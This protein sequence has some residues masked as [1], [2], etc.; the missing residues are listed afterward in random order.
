MKS[1]YEDH[2]DKFAKKIRE[3]HKMGC[4]A[5]SIAYR[6]MVKNTLDTPPPR[7]GRIYH[8]VKGKAKHQAS[9]PGEPPAPLTRALIN[10]IKTHWDEGEKKSYV[11]SDSDYAIEL[12]F[13]APNRDKPLEARPFFKPTM[14][15]PENQQQMAE[16]FQKA[17]REGMK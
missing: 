2:S 4:I 17:F 13:G 15:A 16:I 14:D 9:A 6:D 8:D 1:G 12:E 7:T 11:Y 10:S 5:M 3:A